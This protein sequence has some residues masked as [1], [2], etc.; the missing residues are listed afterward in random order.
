[1]LSHPN[2]GVHD[3]FR[4]LTCN[5]VNIYIII[6]ILD[7]YIYIHIHFVIHELMGARVV[8]LGPFHLSILAST[9]RALS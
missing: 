7:I 9:S 4:L 1:M 8:M 6:Y 2:F 3:K 5:Y